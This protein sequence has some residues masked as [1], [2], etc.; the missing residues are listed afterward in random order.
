MASKELS[1]TAGPATTAAVK[2]FVFFSIATATPTA[3][4]FFFSVVLFLFSF[5]REDLPELAVL[6]EGIN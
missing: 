6:P 4:A 2:G 3:T 5:R 1:R